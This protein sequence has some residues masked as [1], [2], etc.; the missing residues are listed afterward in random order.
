MVRSAMCSGWDWQ[1]LVHVLSKGARLFRRGR[2]LS[3]VCCLTRILRPFITF[4]ETGHDKTAGL[5]VLSCFFLVV[6]FVGG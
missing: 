3:F 5:A 2:V 6:P 4:D 1:S